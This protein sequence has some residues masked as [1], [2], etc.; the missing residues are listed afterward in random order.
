MKRERTSM[1]HNLSVNNCCCCVAAPHRFLRF[2]PRFSLSLITF[3]T[4]IVRRSMC[5]S[6]SGPAL[7]YYTYCIPC[8]CLACLYANT[9][10]SQPR[11][12]M[13]NLYRAIMKAPS[14]HFGHMQPNVQPRDYL[15]FRDHTAI[16][17][18]KWFCP[19][20]PRIS[21]QRTGSTTTRAHVKPFND[22]HR[23]SLPRP[24]RYPS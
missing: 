15:P 20:W 7:H 4:K 14:Q 6:E 11:L 2:A 5:N 19:P 3:P 23:T 12:G 22:G 13:Q 18:A 17:C 21:T 10:S 24:R 1:R 9:E 8:W 16:N